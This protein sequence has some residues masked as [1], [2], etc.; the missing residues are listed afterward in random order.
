MRGHVKADLEVRDGGEACVPLG[1]YVPCALLFF[2]GRPYP[3]K[4]PVVAPGGEPAVNR[5]PWWQ[6]V[7]KQPRGAARPHDI[8]DA[9]DDLAHR[10]GPRPARCAGLRQVRRDPRPTT[11]A[12]SVW[13][14]V[15][16]RLCCCR[17]VGVHM[18]YPRLVGETP[19]N[20]GGSP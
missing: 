7:R 11:S 3:F 6:V 9:V 5:P 1:L 10:P 13:Y 16:G 20:H 19:W 17:V 8:E 14:R 15:T 4:A 12:R 2:D 18:A